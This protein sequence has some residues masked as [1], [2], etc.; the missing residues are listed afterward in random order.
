MGATVKRTFG[1]ERNLGDIV[2]N[3]QTKSVFCNIQ[4]GF[5]TKTIN[6][7]KRQDNCYDI[8]VSKFNSEETIKIGQTFPVTKKDGS[9]VEGLTQTKIGLFKRYD[10]QKGKEVTDTSDALFLTTHKLKEPKE[11]GTKGFQKV[12]FITGKFG[13]ELV[14]ETQQKSA[15]EEP[16]VQTPEYDDDNEELPF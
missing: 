15:P 8:V 14:E 12:G 11:I 13:I 4:L 5:F 10:S 6:L 2:Y 1:K 9:T 3:P 16:V 7:V